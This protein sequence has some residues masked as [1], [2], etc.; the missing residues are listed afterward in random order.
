VTRPVLVVGAGLAGAVHARALAEG[1][2]AVRV[3]DRRRHVAGN[4]YDEVDVTGVRRHVY[5]P[6]LFHTNSPRVAAFLERFAEFVPYEHRV[7]VALPDGSGFVPLPVNR[8]TVRRVLGVDAASG[9]G[10]RDALAREAVPHAEPRNA[11]E[12]LEARIGRRLTDLLYRPYSRKMWGVELE[13]LAASVVR[14]IP[15]RHDDESRYFPDHRFQGLPRDGYGDMVLR[16]LDHPRVRVETGVAFER[17][18]LRASS[19]CFAS[20]SIDEWFGEVFGPLP[21]RSLRFHARAALPAEEAGPTAQVNFADDSP[22]TRRTDWAML[23]CHRV[24]ETGRRTVTYEEPCDARDNGGERYYPVPDGDG[25]NAALHARYRALADR[26]PRVR[27]VGRCGTY[28][29]L[30][31]DQVVAQSLESARA[32]LAGRVPERGAA[33]A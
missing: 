15:V 27:F 32:F 8:Q 4:A 33:P 17:S 2:R 22:F 18:M 6:H 14:R 30:D 11:A 28:R 3:I 19:F 24:R 31:M 16:M 20:V 5:G 25:R 26:E 12:W 21:Y 9:D 13:A 23:P 29:Y 7:S 1:G 10:V